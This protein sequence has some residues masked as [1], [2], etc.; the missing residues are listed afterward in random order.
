MVSGGVSGL[1]HGGDLAAAR[2]RFPDAPE[3][4][5]DLSTGINPR[6]WPDPAP[7]PPLPLEALTRLPEPDAI[8]ALEAVAAAR[9]Q[10]PSPDHV[11]AAPGTQLLLPLVAGLVPRGAARILAPTY[12]EHRR[13]AALAGHVAEEVAEVAE[14]HG[15]AIATVVN[16]NNPDGRIVSRE[17]LLAVAGA[18]RLL[19]VDE[20]FMEVGPKGA[21]MA[22]E[23]DRPGLIVL[24]SFGKFHGLAGLRLGFAIAAPETLAPLRALLGPWA[25]TGPAIAHGTAALADEEWAEATRTVLRSMGA[26]LDE[27]LR[28]HRLEVLGGTPLFRLARCPDGTYEGLGR[29]G[30]LVRAFPDRPGLLRFG[31]PPDDPALGRLDRALEPVVSPLHPL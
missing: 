16:P 4:F 8:R 30:I 17:A 7:L 22:P 9:Y 31:L 2:R 3:P 12:A 5:L 27:V 25:V 24:R 19:V 6:P 10:A 29:Q 13:A 26:R 1:P 11:L 18:V 23:A 20:A 15:A 14:L 28:R 21:S